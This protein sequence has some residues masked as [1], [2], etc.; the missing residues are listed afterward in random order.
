MRP[1]EHA[2][3]ALPDTPLPDTP[4]PIDV[5]PATD[6]PWQ[7]LDPRMLLVHPIIELRRAI[8]PLLAILV[9]GHSSGHGDIWSLAIAGLIMLAAVLRWFTTKYR[10]TPDRLQL[11]KG[12]VRRTTI[13]VRV[14]RIRTVDVTAH[15]LH[16]VLGLAKVT[17]GTGTSDRRGRGG[18]ELDGLAIETAD[19]LRAQL[20]HRLTVTVAAPGRHTAIDPGSNG[21]EELIVG[22]EP[23]WVWYAPFT[24]SGLVTGAALIGF[25]WRL[26]QQAQINLRRIGPLRWAADELR[27][28]SIWLDVGAVIV[29]VV[30]FVAVA[31]TAGY[32]LSFWNFRLTRHSGGSLHISR[33]LLTTRRTSIERAR[34]AGVETSEPLLLRLVGGAKCLTIA[35][36]LR[37]GRGAERGGTVLLPPAPRAV[38]HSVASEVLGTGEPI[39]SQL[40]AHGPRA[41]QRRYVRT[42]AGAVLVS[43][44]VTLVGTVLAGGDGA[45]VTAIVVVPVTMVAGVLLAADRYRSLGHTWSDGFLVTR[46]GSIVRRHNVLSA[47][48]II[49]WNVRAT[50]WQRR[51]GLVTLTATT[52]AGRQRYPVADIATRDAI[53]FAAH[54]VPGLLEEFLADRDDAPSVRPARSGTMTGMPGEAARSTVPVLDVG[55]TH[56][57]CALVDLASWDVVGRA[58]RLPLD[59]TGAAA[60]IID[61]LL[62]AAAGIAAPAGA[63]WGVAMPDPFDY[64]TGVALF[65]G[66]GKFESLYGHDIRAALLAGLPA[67][68]ADVA[69]INDADAF[70]LGEWLHGAASGTARCAGLT[71]GTGVG[72]GFVADGQV[73]DCGPDVPP[74]GRAHRLQVAGAPLE[75]LMSRRALRRAYASRTGL[76]A[77]EVPDVA[78]ICARARSGEPAAT[79]TIAHALRTL[80]AV[81]APWIVRFG[82]DVVVIGGSM[83]ASWDVLEPPFVEGF[84]SI[85]EPPRLAVAADADRAPLLGAARRASEVS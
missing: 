37:V 34:L 55:G 77:E 83:A 7:R 52:A 39:E 69:F 43:A 35:T 22:L 78:E 64:A 28:T 21:P 31:S 54:G 66:V 27:T 2:G 30:V 11:R 84:G 59:A 1:D 58:T 26:V 49:G 36:G 46:F 15:A 62:E 40:T 48:S 18:L 32:V 85:A 24:L 67:S 14:E 6:Q 53:S 79:S 41:R 25:G 3:T 12:L 10:V 29:V 74:G 61:A 8:V 4:A 65:E 72:S 80:G 75:N 76:D 17:I 68:P 51:L 20:L 42:L 38:A 70:V 19:A 16:R 60:G 71:L 57:T 81:L 50:I 47:S 63:V 13:D 9:A 5:V 56:V 33:G 23:S 44:I 45:L 82:A 73:V